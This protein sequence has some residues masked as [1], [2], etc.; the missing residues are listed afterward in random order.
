[1]PRFLLFLFSVLLL[2]PSVGAGLSLPV[3]AWQPG[4]PLSLDQAW[5]LAR[6][7]NYDLAAAR[8][9]VEAAE[10][11]IL[12]A[13]TAPNPQLSFSAN[14]I[15]PA[16]GVGGGS[17]RE[18]R[19]DSTLRIDQT[20][21]RGG[22]RAL[23]VKAAT[24]GRDASLG[25]LADTLRQQMM[26][27]AAAYYD[28]LA[29]QEREVVATEAAALYGQTLKA[30]ELRQ[31]AG[32]L[33][34]ADVA[35]IRTDALRAGNDAS[36][37]LLERQRAQL[38]LAGLIG[39]EAQAIRIKVQAQWPTAAFDGD[40]DLAAALAQLE[41]RPDI[42]AAQ[43]RIDA[44]QANR[45]LARASRKRDVSVGIQAEHYPPDNGNSLGFTVSVPLFFGNDFSGD[46]AKAEADYGAALD[47]LQRT[48]GEAAAELQ[49]LAA[50][51]TV[52][53]DRLLRSR[54]ELLPAAKKSAA[55]A[56]FAFKNGAMGVMD[57]LDARRT[58]RAVELEAASAQADY[59]KAWQA[60][61]LA[62][63]DETTR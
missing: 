54:D 22:K 40:G 34:P 56:D 5:A 8:R 9:N 7:K 57:L 12:S 62:T 59:A 61:R 6:E 45:E 52:A 50:E 18:K 14:S 20:L 63:Q 2:C 21:E 15:N 30:A 33:A 48:R 37:A 58:L 24:A 49:R 35:R 28:L 36:Q 26:A 55:A 32:D 53:L 38:A 19:V 42:R 46:F 44:A 3:P 41:Q 23:R 39:Q 29:A 25:D 27:V 1:M 13:D 17:W 60:W 4:A 16:L 31:R 11:G 47:A 43:S 10:A 51:R